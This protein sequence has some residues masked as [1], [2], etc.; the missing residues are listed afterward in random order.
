MLNIGKL[1]AGGE[2]YYLTT[3]AQSVDDYYTGSGEAPG[4]WCG[5][6]AELLGLDGRVDA[7]GL[8]LLLGVHTESSAAIC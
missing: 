7:E 3:V 6:N 2:D 1:A 8:R 5:R 4:R